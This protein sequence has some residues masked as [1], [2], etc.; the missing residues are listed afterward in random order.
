LALAPS[1]LSPFGSPAL[2]LSR[3][4]ALS[5]FGSL[6]LW[7]LPLPHTSTDNSQ[8][9]LLFPSRLLLP[10]ARQLPLQ[11]PIQ[12]RRQQASTHEGNARYRCANRTEEP[13]RKT[14]G[15][16]NRRMETGNRA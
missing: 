16:Y 15:R 6:A 10:F 13:N 14:F 7:L 4:L 8:L 1:A 12:R 5:P 9:H 3:P 11:P 2:W